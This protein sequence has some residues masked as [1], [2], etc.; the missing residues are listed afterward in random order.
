MKIKLVPIPRGFV[1][2]SSNLSSLSLT[3]SRDGVL[4]VVCSKSRLE[5]AVGK[6]EDATFVDALLG[7][8]QGVSKGIYYLLV[9]S[10]SSGIEAR[11]ETIARQVDEVQII[12]F[13]GKP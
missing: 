13:P 8:I 6:S 7:V 5:M 10:K 3:T 4:D 12:P 2:E 9:V 11:S 1:L